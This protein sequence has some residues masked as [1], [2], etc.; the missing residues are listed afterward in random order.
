MAIRVYF[1]CGET[2]NMLLNLLKGGP[3]SVFTVWELPNSEN[4]YS[5]TGITVLAEVEQTASTTGK[6]DHSLTIASYLPV[7]RILYKSAPTSFQDA[8]LVVIFYSLI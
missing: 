4:I 6:W 3:L 5:S 8:Y 1:L 2:L 7:V